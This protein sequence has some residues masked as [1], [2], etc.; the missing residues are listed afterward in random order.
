MKDNY[1]RFMHAFNELH[2]V[3]AYRVNRRRETHFGELMGLA[4]KKKD[5]VVKAYTTEIDFY[6]ELRNLLIHHSLEGEVAAYPSD[7][8]IREVE[9]VT[10]QI[11]YSKKVKDLFLKRV[12]T[13]NIDDPL[14]KVLNTVSRVR[15]TQFPVFDGAELAGM[16]SSVGITKY[17]ARAKGQEMGNLMNTTVRQILMLEDDRDFYR[18]ISQETSIFDIEEV[19]QRQ[20]KDGHFSFT[21]LISRQGSIT[22]KDDLIGIIT[23]WDIPKVV[24]NK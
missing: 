18:V 7:A 24:A 17:I 8:L 14:D 1:Q 9:W 22:G 11:K 2:T 13:F 4:N 6:R 20:M 15:Y 21:L 10:Q 3:I 5:K 19:F 23:P 16:L 12:R